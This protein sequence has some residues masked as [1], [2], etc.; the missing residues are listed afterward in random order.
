MNLLSNILSNNLWFSFLNFIYNLILLAWHWFFPFFFLLFLF[1]F[2][3]DRCSIPSREVSILW[4]YL[5]ITLLFSSYVYLIFL[6]HLSHKRL[7]VSKIP[8]SFLFFF[9]VLKEDYRINGL[10]FGLF[11]IICSVFLFYGDN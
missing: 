11:F 4:S 2:S 8:F 3:L 6:E 7:K 9:L 1:M 5:D 10:H